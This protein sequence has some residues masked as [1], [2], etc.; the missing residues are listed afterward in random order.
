MFSSSEEKFLNNVN[1]YIYI[2]SQDVTLYILQI[3][4][5]YCNI[6]EGKVG[7]S[8]YR[9]YYRCVVLPPNLSGYNLY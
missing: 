6:K 7:V 1:F 3:K 4:Y 9:V 5:T 8:F 2:G